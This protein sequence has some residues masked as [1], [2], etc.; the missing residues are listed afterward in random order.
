MAPILILAA[1]ALGLPAWPAGAQVGA[2]EF[3]QLDKDKDGFLS[4]EEAKGTAYEQRFDRL[5]Q[6]SDGKLSQKEAT[7]PAVGSAQ[8]SAERTAEPPPRPHERPTG[9]K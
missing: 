9:G 1:L 2:E 5:D 3:R 7:V 4:R 6:D 8:S